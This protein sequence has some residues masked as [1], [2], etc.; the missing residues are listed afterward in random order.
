M[1]RAIEK[2][3]HRVEDPRMVHGRAVMELNDRYL[4][5]LRRELTRAQARLGRA[6]R[7]R[8]SLIE[9]NGELRRLLRAHGLELPRRVAKRRPARPTK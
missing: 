8:D 3:F 1:S 2:R 5:L 9:Q 6:E 7:Q 4:V